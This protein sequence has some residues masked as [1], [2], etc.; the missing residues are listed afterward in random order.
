MFKKFRIFEIGRNSNFL[1]RIFVLSVPSAVVLLILALSNFLSPL[2]ATLSYGAIVIFNMFLLL[3]ISIE[4]QKLKRYINSLGEEEFN[5]DIF[6]SENEVK[7]IA[8][9][10]KSMHQ[11]FQAKADALKAKAVSDT[12]VLDTLPDPILMMERTGNIL[13]AN[14]SSKILLGDRIVG[15]N[16]E[17]I[18]K[19]DRMIEALS[20]V[21]KEKS[22]SESVAFYMPEPINKKIYAH[23]K[24][25]P[26]TPISR[27]FAVISLY[28][29]TK[30]I[31]LEKMQSDFVANA[32]HELRTPLAVI[33]GFIETLQTTAKDDPDAR[34]QFL[35]IMAGQAS[36]MSSLIENLLSLS[37]I[38]LSQDE[39][40]KDKVDVLKIVQEV[41]NALKLKADSQNMKIVVNS[42]QKISKIIADSGQIKQ[43]IQ[44][45]TD[46]AIKYG[47]K[48][49]EITLSIK[50]VE[51]IPASKSMR[52]SKGKAVVVSINNK[53]PKISPDK[54][55]RLTER[56]YRLQEH[57]NLGIK[58]TGLGLS[59]AK[60]IV[61]HHRGNITV[62]STTRNGT[63][64]S[65][66]LPLD[67]R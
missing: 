20:K 45:L 13:E 46:N 52:V 43:L 47:L 10:A 5:Q 65:V 25:L 66:Y 67:P 15:K 34:D 31:K 29:L 54:L 17:E 56:F 62:S 26:W 48:N 51:K 57:K 14:S 58:G 4:L 12:A 35:K 27:A 37:K 39:P 8:E 3:P 44:N 6:L 7:E 18:F 1:L 61:L 50:K 63:T 42:P 32:S 33:T 22:D 36:F 16:T 9:A 59:I 21:I 24:R 28:D 53:G 2:S 40:L 11:T 19:S 60:Q 49:S 30:A 64:F 23:I 41:V 38:E 55:A